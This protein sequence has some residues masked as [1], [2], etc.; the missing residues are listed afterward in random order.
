MAYPDGPPLSIGMVVQPNVNMKGMPEEYW[1]AYQNAN[2]VFR[3]LIE[4]EC[5]V[6]I[7]SE[8][9]ATLSTL[10]QNLVLQATS[11]KQED[12]MV[13]DNTHN[14]LDF[15][16]LDQSTRM[17]MISNFQ[18]NLLPGIVSDDCDCRVSKEYANG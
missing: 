5:L 17:T 12:S 13:C 7:D 11:S 10:E 3:Q 9:G 1:S 6:I 16:T 8:D 18:K 2:E 15:T 14:Y 4:E